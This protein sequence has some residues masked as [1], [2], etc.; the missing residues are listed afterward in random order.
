MEDKKL[1]K[2]SEITLEEAIDI[3]K[4]C[5]G[6]EEHRAKDYK[7]KIEKGFSEEGK[8][9]KLHHFEDGSGADMLFDESSGVIFCENTSIV[10][11]YYINYYRAIKY[12][13]KKGFD[14]EDVNKKSWL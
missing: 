8:R 6:F 3:L 12:L 14:L 11:D 13:E 5:K 1:R 9:A 10:G 2:L 7:L 4:I